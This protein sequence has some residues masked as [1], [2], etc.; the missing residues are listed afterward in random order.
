[1]SNENRLNSAAIDGLLL[2]TVTVIASLSHSLLG[3]TGMV[4]ATIIW[5]LKFGGCIY[6][7]N[8]C[9][10]RQTL[11]CGGATYGDTFK[12]GILVCLF[13]SFVCAAYMFMS[14]T[15]LFPEQADLAVEQVRTIME[16]S[17]KLSATDQQAFNSAMDRLP[18]VIF[19]TNFIYYT[20]IGAVMSSVIANFTKTE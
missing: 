17:N 5:I 20:I 3:I 15:I 10:R 11:S 4:A 2:S 7:L 12:Y 14:F 18:Q 16:S 1:M 6:V 19:I 9:M 13:S 8:W